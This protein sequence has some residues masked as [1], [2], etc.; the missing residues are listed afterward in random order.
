MI[1]WS[2]NTQPGTTTHVSI[3]TFKGGEVNVNINIGSDEP[4]NTVTR[5]VVDAFM[6]E[7]HHPM[8]LMLTMEALRRQF[9]CAQFALYLPYIP[10]A[11][12][13][14]VCNPGE[15]HALKVFGQLINS[16]KFQQ[17]IVIDP[18]SDVAAGVI[19][20]LAP[21]TQVDIFEDIHNFSEWWI[22]APDLG[23][24]KKAEKFAKHVGA[25]GVI[26][27]MKTRNPL[28]GE[29]TGQSV[30][31]ATE[32]ELSNQKLLVLDDICDGGRTFVGVHALLNDFAPERLELAVTHGIFSYGTTVVTDLYDMVHTTN[33]WNKDLLNEPKLNVI[34]VR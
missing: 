17:V 15:S 6:T 14:R 4:D 7:P 24:L 32:D 31:G 3:S 12:Q 21:Y 33:S 19:D 34:D 13:D 25:R 30:M 20:N 9:P 23:A 26:A 28:T 11:R 1:T 16:L 22:V 10:Y 5:V 8:A 18:H 27:C 2:N 29:I